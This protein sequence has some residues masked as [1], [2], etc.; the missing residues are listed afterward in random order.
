LK[1][2]R[3]QLPKI[4]DEFYET[5]AESVEVHGTDAAD[6]AEVVRQGDGVT[7][8]L[9]ASA[10]GE[11][12]FQRTVRTGDT[13]E[14]RI[15]LKKGDD[16]VVTRGRDA[17]ALK[18]RVAAGPGADSLDDSAAGETRFYDHDGKGRVVAGPGTEESD[19]PYTH[20]LDRAKYPLRDFGSATIPTV[21]IA[22][23]GDLGLFLGAGVDFFRYGFRQHAGWQGDRGA[24][25]A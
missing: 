16:R 3:N 8:T 12:Y 4:A 2:R 20:P 9:R 22:G 1:S 25:S 5:L 10:E 6:F 13:E 24:R 17:R 15:H 7:V 23:G 19:K 11:P 18:V 14:V 21:V